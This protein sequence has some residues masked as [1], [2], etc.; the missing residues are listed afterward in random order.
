MNRIIYLVTSFICIIVVSFGCD[1]SRL[2]DHTV[3][4][5]SGGWAADKMMEF[6][7][8]VNDSKKS[9]D[10]LLH[11]RNS[12][13][14]KYS[15]IWLFIETKSPAGNALRDTLEIRLAD[16]KGKW[17]GKGIGNIHE[18]L[19]PYKQNILFPDWGI[20]HVTISQ[21]MREQALEHI[22][23]IGL[24]LQFHNQAK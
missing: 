1:K 22:I 10:I 4:I 24:R 21:A 7:M 18:M 23:D 12:G 2:Y 11:I 5:P 17:N 8:P 20:Y 19:V 3:S 13:D 9:Y 15:N 14:Y 6:D 16:D